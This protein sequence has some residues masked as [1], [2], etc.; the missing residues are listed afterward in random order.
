M[1]PLEYYNLLILG[2]GDSFPS[3]LNSESEARGVAFLTHLV[4]LES[5]ITW[6][7][8]PRLGLSSLLFWVFSLTCDSKKGSNKIHALPTSNPKCLLINPFTVYLNPCFHFTY[9][10][11]YPSN[12]DEC[13]EDGSLPPPISFPLSLPLCSHAYDHGLEQKVQ[14]LQLCSISTSELPHYPIPGA[15]GPPC[16]CSDTL[17]CI[18][19]G[20][21]FL[22]PDNSICICS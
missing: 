8:P 2:Y 3:S 14:S 6:F 7:Y 11:T 21:L 10:M 1:R 4:Q 16:C 15:P 19:L 18:L 9:Q 5:S 13:Q 12:L 17:S 22:H 20:A